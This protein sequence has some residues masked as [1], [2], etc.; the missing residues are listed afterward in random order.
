MSKDYILF[1]IERPTYEDARKSLEDLK[2][3]NFEDLVKGGEW[4]SRSDVNGKINKYID[5]D[6]SGM[7]Y[8]NYFHWGY[9][10]ACDSLNS[11]SP[12]RSWYNP[13]IRKS[14]ESCKFY[15]DSPSTALALRKYIASQFRPSAAK[16]I[17]EMFGAKR[18][19]DPC[20][21]WGDRL[22]AAATV[23]DLEL[24]Y[25][26]DVNTLVFAGYTEQIRDLGIDPSKIFLEH[27]GCEEDPPLEN[28][29]DLVFTSPPYFKVEK[30]NGHDQSHRKYKKFNDW[31]SGFL[32][33]TCD[34]CWGVLKSGGHMIFNISDVYANHEYNKICNP[35][36]EY[37]VNNLEGC[38][39]VGTIGYRMAKRIQSKSDE[40]GTFCEPVIIFKKR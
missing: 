15:K 21:G 28:N 38:E 36:I 6:K 27:K 16:A 3:S 10:M 14:V 11:P 4:Y 30:Y 20:G 34:N 35:L 22:A 13:K 26:R 17:Y 8:S 24:Y 32:F 2:G 33:K 39:Y 12:L 29:F 5:S 37:C 40:V 7:K 18:I 1:P 23:K 25:T 9:R 31:L 19:Y